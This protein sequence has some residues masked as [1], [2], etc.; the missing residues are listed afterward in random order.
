M[1]FFTLAAAALAFSS[2][3]SATVLPRQADA[4]GARGACTKTRNGQACLESE[5]SLRGGPA[6]CIVQNT[7]PNGSKG[8]FCAA[9][10]CTGGKVLVSVARDGSPGTSYQTCVL[11]ASCPAAGTQIVSN[12]GKLA[13]PTWLCHDRLS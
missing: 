9:D 11:A 7:G 3:T 12:G 4:K 2:F 10:A 8:P 13:L 5:G 1:H 6:K